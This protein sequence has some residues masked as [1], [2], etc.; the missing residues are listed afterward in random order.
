MVGEGN[1]A[2]ALRVEV[3]FCLQVLPDFQSARKPY[4]RIFR[5]AK[6]FTMCC[7]QKHFVKM[8][9]DK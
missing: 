4:K 1:D 6:K 3:K 9:S 5:H 2:Q 8:R 7:A